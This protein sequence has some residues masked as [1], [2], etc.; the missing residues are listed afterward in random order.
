MLQIISFGLANS[1]HAMGSGQL[2]GSPMSEY[3]DTQKSDTINIDAPEKDGEHVHVLHR[4]RKRAGFMEEEL[5]VFNSM[6]EAV[7]EVATAIR[8]SKSVD[9]HPKLYNAIMDQIGFSPE[10]LM[11]ALNHLLDNKSRGVGFVA[12]D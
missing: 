12:T 1:K 8:E 9:V 10:A 3:L 7:K 11:V 6:I 2:L 4:K 5:S